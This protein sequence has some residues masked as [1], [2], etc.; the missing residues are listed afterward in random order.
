M[1][2]IFLP[3]MNRWRLVASDDSIVVL[4]K[5]NTS[6]RLPRRYAGSLLAEGII[7]DQKYLPKWSLAGKT[8][9][10]VGAGAGETAWFF[11]SHGASR[12]IAVEPDSQVARFLKLN[13]AANEWPIEILGER[14]SG[15]LLNRKHDFLKMDCEGC[16]ILLLDEAV[17]KLKACRIEMHYGPNDSTFKALVSKFNL[18]RYSD[19]VWGKD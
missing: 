3:S 12:V 4:Q 18:R 7:W 13:T 17:S 1:L 2:A 10:D 14:F 15:E 16:E 8:V 6:I 5:E 11:L 19:D 9:L